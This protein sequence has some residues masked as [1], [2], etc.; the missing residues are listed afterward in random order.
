MVGQ[1]LL[2]IRCVAVCTPQ[3]DIS[4]DKPQEDIW[5]TRYRQSIDESG[6]TNA[7]LLI[8]NDTNTSKTHPYYIEIYL[9]VNTYEKIIYF[10]INYNAYLAFEQGFNSQ[11]C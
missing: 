4:K 2:D 10:P 5:K 7:D 6:Y 8:N 11:R 1:D 9:D 3:A